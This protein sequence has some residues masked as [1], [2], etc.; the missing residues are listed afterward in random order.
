MP[1]D[2]RHAA[3]ILRA[4]WKFIAYRSA[5]M[6]FA[7]L[8]RT[9]YRSVFV[10]RAALRFSVRNSAFKMLATVYGYVGLRR[11]KYCDLKADFG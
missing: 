8:R 2:V 5:F 7:V 11:K 1:G 4:V 9:V 6:L 10:L 3:Y